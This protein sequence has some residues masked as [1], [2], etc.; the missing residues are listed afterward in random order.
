MLE[1]TALRLLEST[2]AG[3]G[4]EKDP[5]LDGSAEIAIWFCLDGASWGLLCLSVACVP[6]SHF[7]SFSDGFISTS[8]GFWTTG[9]ECLFISWLEPSAGLTL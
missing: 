4:Q 1:G 5:S 8:F 2:Q 7:S 6:V 9:E 3:A